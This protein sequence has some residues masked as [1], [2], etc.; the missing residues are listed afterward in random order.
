MPDLDPQPDFPDEER[1]PARG[2][3]RGQGHS[4]PEGGGRVVRLISYNIQTGTTTS[5]Y[6]HYL[7]QGWKQMLP[8]AQRMDNLARIA[9]VLGDY[10]VVGLQEVDAG[11]LRSG[12]INQTEYIAHR[13]AFPYWY[14]Q[15]TRRIG[16]FAQHSNG[17]LSRFKPSEVDD[18]R[19]PGAIPGRGALFVRF[20]AG[21]ESLV[22]VILHLALGRRSRT[23]QLAYI[24]EL[25][26]EYHHVVI[27]GDMNC[28]SDSPEMRTLVTSGNLCEPAHNLYT[29]P[30]WR[31]E[32]NIDHI[33]V[34][35]SLQVERVR[36]LEHT[37]SDHLPIAMDVVLPEAIR[38]TPSRG[39]D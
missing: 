17:F 4:A 30:S 15:T 14:H 10:D 26:S 25:A 37:Y 22:I 20:G 38:L 27:M 39:D 28:R 5:R 8:H 11:S 29:F 18:H 19:L 36:V 35:P 31:P 2:N 23:R 13:A 3:G 9:E 1:A 6:R 12:F 33:L 16:V 34:S 32:R 7:T 21:R 24:R